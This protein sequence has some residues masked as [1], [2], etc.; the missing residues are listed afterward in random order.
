MTKHIDVCE[1]EAQVKLKLSVTKIAE[2]I[3]YFIFFIKLPF[4]TYNWSFNFA[5]PL[6][7]QPVHLRLHAR[8]GARVAKVP[9]L[10][11]RISDGLILFAS[12]KRRR[13]V[14]RKFALI[15]IFIPLKT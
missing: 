13:L 2:A 12:S 6:V 11:G 1:H 14:A 7:T 8:S 9:K 10:F 15:L 3:C 5:V 4:S